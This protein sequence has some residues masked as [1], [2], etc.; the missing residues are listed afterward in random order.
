MR[1]NDTGL[2]RHNFTSV[3]DAQFRNDHLTG[4]FNVSENLDS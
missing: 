3:T 4:R 2:T 1:A